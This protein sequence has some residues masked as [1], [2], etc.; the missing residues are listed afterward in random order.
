MPP[1]AHDLLDT[2]LYNGSIYTMEADCPVC[3]AL[4]LADDRIVAVGALEDLRP[5]LSPHGEM[6]D[7]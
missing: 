7:L 2:I 6:I 1:A 4:G 3:E 5:M